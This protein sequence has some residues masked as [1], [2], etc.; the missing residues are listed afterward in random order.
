SERAFVRGTVDSGTQLVSTGVRRLT[1]GQQVK[2]KSDF[3]TSIDSQE[4]LS[5]STDSQPSQGATP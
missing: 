5:A 2:R 3:T 4:I 1:P